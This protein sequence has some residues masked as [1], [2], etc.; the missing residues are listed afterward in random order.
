MII[1]RDAS[2]VIA[3]VIPSGLLNHK[4][5]EEGDAKADRLFRR[6]TLQTV[7]KLEVW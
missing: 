5:E 2:L 4:I 1:V 3:S 7:E 6:Q